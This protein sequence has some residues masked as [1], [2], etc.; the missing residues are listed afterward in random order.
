[1]SKNDDAMVGIVL[2]ILGIAAIAAIVSKKCPIC[3]K[4]VQRGIS[5]CP[6]CESQI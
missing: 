5:V 1:M 6:H 2:G 4:T 3:N